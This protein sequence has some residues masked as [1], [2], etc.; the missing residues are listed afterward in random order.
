MERG[1]VRDPLFSPDGR[2]VAFAGRDTVAWDADSH[3]FVVTAD[4]SSSAPERVAPQTD[5]P[6]LGFP[7]MPAPMCWIGADEVSMLMADRGTVAI[8]RARVGQPAA[9]EVFAGEMQVDG[10]SARVGRRAFAFTASWPDR[11]G[12]GVHGRSRRAPNRLRSRAST[13]SSSRRS[14]S[15]RSPARRSR[16]PTA[17][18]S[19]TSRFSRPA[20]RGRVRCTSISTAARTRFWP[21][22]RWIGLHQAIVA[23][24]YAFVLPNPRGSSSYGQ[25]FTV[26]VHRRLGRRRLRGHPRLLR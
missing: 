22:G 10:F 2:T 21:S 13:R 12:R 14:S 23:A 25:D 8:Q 3:V 18:R 24:G 7:G 20:A 15:P 17:P 5:R 16:A 11:P 4:A 19:S 6:V 1:V 26:R 9:R